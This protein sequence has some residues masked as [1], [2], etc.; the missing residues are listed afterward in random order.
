MHQLLTPFHPLASER[1]AVSH[2]NVQDCA[3]TAGCNKNRNTQ[4]TSLEG[5]LVEAETVTTTL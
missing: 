2:L 3:P 1:Q 4:D 5:K